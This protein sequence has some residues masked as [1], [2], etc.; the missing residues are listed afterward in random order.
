[1][2]V[3]RINKDSSEQR[4]ITVDFSEWLDTDETIASTT[5]PVIVVEMLATWQSGVWSSNPPIV[6]P[7]ADTTPLQLET[8]VTVTGG[9]MVQLWVGVGTPGVTYKLTF[10]ATGSTSNRV[11]QIDILV[12]VRAPL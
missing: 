11:A 3:G 6:D 7:I 1:M 4:R 5:T 12:S 9:Q 10:D 2:L 8:M